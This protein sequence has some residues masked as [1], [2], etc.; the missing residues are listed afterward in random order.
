VVMLQ[1]RVARSAHAAGEASPDDYLVLDL[2]SGRYFGLGEVGGF[3]WQRLD[4]SLDLA[5][6]AAAVSDHFEVPVEQAR[7]DLLEFVAQLIA[8]GLAEASSP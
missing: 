4:G 3:I 6:V 5:A 2:S 1:D 7:E 8:D